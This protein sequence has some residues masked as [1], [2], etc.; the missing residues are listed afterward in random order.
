MLARGERE[1]NQLL[2]KFVCCRFAFV[3]LRPPR[4]FRS[5]WNKCTSHTGEQMCFWFHCTVKNYQ[6]LSTL[7][8]PRET[9]K[10]I[11]LWRFIMFSCR[12]M[13]NQTTAK[14]HLHHHEL[15]LWRLR[16]ASRLLRHLLCCVC[17]H[18][19]VFRT[20]FQHVKS[21][22]LCAPDRFQKLSTNNDGS[23]KP[24]LVSQFQP[25]KIRCKFPFEFGTG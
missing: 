7:Q 20:Y 5:L 6:K 19:G 8:D 25:Q 17:V 18:P 14:A 12:I 24:W 22:W 11:G 16:L 23:A 2:L 15:E 4:V 21:Q 9:V 10:T 1:I 13:S 3:F